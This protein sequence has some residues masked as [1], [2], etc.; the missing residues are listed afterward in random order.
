MGSPKS[1]PD[2][3]FC[4]KVLH[5]LRGGTVKKSFSFFEPST[6]LQELQFTLNGTCS[7]KEIIKRM[8]NRSLVS[9]NHVT[10]STTVADHLSRVGLEGWQASLSHR[11]RDFDRGSGWCGRVRPLLKNI[12]RRAPGERVGGRWTGFWL[13]KQG[14]FELHW[15]HCI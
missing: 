8:S 7:T 1:S 14:F 13:G 5:L 9:N 15:L 11:S 10:C 6:S 3:I 12:E 4:V 2:I